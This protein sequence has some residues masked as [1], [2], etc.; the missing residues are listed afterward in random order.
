MTGKGPIALPK[1]PDVARADALLRRIGEELAR[2]SSRK[3]RFP[4]V[5]LPKELRWEA[6]ELRRIRPQSAPPVVTESPNDLTMFG[7]S[8]GA[9][10]RSR[11]KRASLN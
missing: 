11:A 5:S 7:R 9:Y 10:A 6:K 8:N 3:I 1:R 4:N 2:R